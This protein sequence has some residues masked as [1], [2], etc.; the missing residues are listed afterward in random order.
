MVFLTNGKI[1]W[2]VTWSLKKRT[3][4]SE[5]HTISLLKFCS[6]IMMKDAIFGRRE[7]CFI[8]SSLLPRPSMVK[9]IDKLWK[10]SKTWNIHWAVYCLLFSSISETSELRS[11]RPY[12]KDF[13]AS[14]QKNNNRWNIGP[15]LDEKTVTQYQLAT[16][17]QKMEK[18]F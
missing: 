14:W 17:F 18:F 13:G 1:I 2:R 3:N 16:R 7:S 8:S 6:W 12:F 11:K 15:S 4:W 10:T 5:L 9:M